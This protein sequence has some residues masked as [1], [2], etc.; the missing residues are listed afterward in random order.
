MS[1]D[2]KADFFLANR[3]LIEEWAA[4]RP[5]VASALDRA[6]LDAAAGPAQD[7]DA[8]PDLQVKEDRARVVWLDC[9]SE[10]L[11]AVWVG[12]SWEQG[13]LLSGASPWPELFIRM[14]PV[15]PQAVRDA[16][17]D[18]TASARDTYG[19][20]VKGRWWLR[21]GPVVPRSEPIVIEEYAQF[22]VQRLRDAWVDLNA[23]IRTAVEAT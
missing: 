12:L 9:T 10:P 2:P 21:Y 16:V 18:A 23:V 3:A 20:N 1:D 8:V 7:P 4:L 15:H 13:K 19:L 14:D 17:K 6:L 5:S 11:P 22:C